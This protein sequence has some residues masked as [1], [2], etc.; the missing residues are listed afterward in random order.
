[1]N[2]I[3][4]SIPN[5]G[6]SRTL[7]TQWSEKSQQYIPATIKTAKDKSVTLFCPLGDHHKKAIDRASEILGKKGYK[8]VRLNVETTVYEVVKRRR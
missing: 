5:P 1:M 6:K 4:K 3:T 8:L 2:L 7:L